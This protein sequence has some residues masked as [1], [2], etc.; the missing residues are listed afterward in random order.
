MA[1]LHLFGWETFKFSPS[2]TEH[3]LEKFYRKQVLNILY[4]CLFFISQS[5]DKNICHGLWV[6]E[7]ILTSPLQTLNGFW[8]DWT[9]IKNLMSSTKCVFFRL[10]PK[11]GGQWH[12]TQVHE[13]RPFGPLVLV[14]VFRHLVLGLSVNC[15]GKC[16]AYTNYNTTCSIISVN[17]GTVIGLLHVHSSDFEYTTKLGLN[18]L[19]GMDS[20]F[21]S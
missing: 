8:G 13:L 9:Q 5:I 20:C 11:K 4:L 16:K 2:T 7:T 19:L 6:A 18:C 3:I 21:V 10:I 12:C 15:T 14:A 17:F 1:A